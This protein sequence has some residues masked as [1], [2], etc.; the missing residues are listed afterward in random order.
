MN[1][2]SLFEDPYLRDDMEINRGLPRNGCCCNNGNKS[3]TGNRVGFYLG[4]Y[5]H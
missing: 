3:Q 4:L 5:K 1:L 2:W